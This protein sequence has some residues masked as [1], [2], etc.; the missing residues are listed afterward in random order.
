MGA[1]M[2]GRGCE[3]VA[4]GWVTAGSGERSAGCGWERTGSGA[5]G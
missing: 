2:E 5:E 1:C 3:E 4:E